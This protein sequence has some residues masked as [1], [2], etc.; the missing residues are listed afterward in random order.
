MT[1]NYRKHQ[2]RSASIIFSVYVLA[3]PDMQLHRGIHPLEDGHLEEWI[4][5]RGTIYRRIWKRH[6]AA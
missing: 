3:S 2:Q 5:R 6:I 1:T 4:D